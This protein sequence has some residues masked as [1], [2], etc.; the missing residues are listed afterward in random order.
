MSSKDEIV[1]GVVPPQAWGGRYFLQNNPGGPQPKKSVMIFTPQFREP[2]LFYVQM[3]FANDGGI[4]PGGTP[5]QPA[6]PFS[7]IMVNDGTAIGKVDVTMTRALTA[8]SAS[9]DDSYVISGAPSDPRES[10]W[11]PVSIVAAKKLVINVENTGD[12]GIWID[13]TIVPLKTLTHEQLMSLRWSTSKLGGGGTQRNTLPNTFGFGDVAGTGNN[14]PKRTTASPAPATLLPAD[15][16]RR[17][18]WVSNEGSTRLALR[19]GPHDPD[20]TGGTESWDVILDAKGGAFSR[21][22]SPLDTFWG[23]VRGVWEGGSPSGFA[24]ASSAI[25]FLE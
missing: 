9:M 2:R 20:V 4:V 24:L 18:F 21:Y 19:F 25:Y 13:A 11:L 6:S 12:L 5:G 17:Q 3:R 15:N 7:E 8:Q 10:G 22:Q 1:E 23:E 16:T 14:G